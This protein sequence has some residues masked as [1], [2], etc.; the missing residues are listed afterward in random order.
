MSSRCSPTWNGRTVF[1]RSPFSE[2]NWPREKRFAAYH[3]ASSQ[4]PALYVLHRTSAFLN[5]LFSAYS[6]SAFPPHASVRAN[7]VSLLCPTFSFM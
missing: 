7:R 4:S 6:S 2:D 5:T 1:R 3:G